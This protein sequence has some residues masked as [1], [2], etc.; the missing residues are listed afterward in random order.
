MNSVCY[1]DHTPPDISRLGQPMSSPEHGGPAPEREPQSYIKAGRFHNE[2]SSGRAYTQAQETIFRA[3]CDLS[4]FRFQLSE[5]WHVA[6]LGI[7]P[8]A[9]IAQA[10][11]SIFADSEPV[12]LPAEVLQQLQERRRIAIKQAPWVERH[13]RP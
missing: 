1:A 6:V 2:R 11:D 12:T 10:M 7:P 8:P 13:F 4:S 5:Q 9:E 3:S